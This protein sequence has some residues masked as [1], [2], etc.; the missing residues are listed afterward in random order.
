MNN[1]RIYGFS[2]GTAF[3]YFRWISNYVFFFTFVYNIG[4]EQ[5]KKMHY[6]I[7]FFCILLI[8]ENVIYAIIYAFFHPSKLNLIEKF[9][10]CII[11]DLC[12]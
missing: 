2:K 11:G 8:T 9:D 6:E 12:E 5:L 10:I 7:G 3:N 4:N 1:F